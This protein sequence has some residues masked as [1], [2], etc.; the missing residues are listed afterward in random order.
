MPLILRF[1]LYCPLLWEGKSSLPGVNI[2]LVNT[3]LPLDSVYI[4]R[5]LPGQCFSKIGGYNK[6]LHSPKTSNPDRLVFEQVRLY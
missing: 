1:L 4:F 3:K 2:L 6:M 5:I